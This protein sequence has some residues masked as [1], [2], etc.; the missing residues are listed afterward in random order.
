MLLYAHTHTHPYTH[1]RIIYT[2][3]ISL[4]HSHYLELLYSLW[5]SCFFVKNLRSMT[6]HLDLCLVAPWKCRASPRRC[7]SAYA[8][9]VGLPDDSRAHQS[10]RIAVNSVCS[11]HADV[12]V[13]LSTALDLHRYTS[14][15]SQLA[16]WVLSSNSGLSASIILTYIYCVP[17]QG[18]FVFWVT[19]LLNCCLLGFSR[20]SLAPYLIC[21]IKFPQLQS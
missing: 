6:R 1:A 8:F 19:S 12:W 9:C 13:L 16:T 17:L 21:T 18:L 15:L 3:F 10:L 14:F 4:R 2:T 11:R 5:G 20:T 7:E